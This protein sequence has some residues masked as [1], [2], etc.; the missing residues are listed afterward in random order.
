MV[1]PSATLRQTANSPIV[2]RSTCRPGRRPRRPP[3][4]RCPAARARAA[5]VHFPAIWPAGPS[6]GRCRPAAGRAIAGQSSARAAD[7]R[8]GRITGADNT[9]NANMASFPAG[10]YGGIRFMDCRLARS[11]PHFRGGRQVVQHNRLVT[12]VI[13]FRNSLGVRHRLLKRLG[14]G[15]DRETG[16][17]AETSQEPEKSGLR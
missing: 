17:N 15:P 10:R 3:K 8:A 11:V 16:S 12:P 6:R 4:S 2:D 5:W 7:T 1:L 9:R 14:E 13:R